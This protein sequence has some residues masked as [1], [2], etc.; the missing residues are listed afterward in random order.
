MSEIESTSAAAARS[1]SVG[2]SVRFVRRHLA[3]LEHVGDALPVLPVRADRDW[4]RI[5]DQ[6]L[7]AEVGFGLV[8]AVAL[9]AV[10]FE[11]FRRCGAAGDRARAGVAFAGMAAGAAGAALRSGAGD[12]ADVNDAS[13]STRRAQNSKRFIGF[14]GR[15]GAE[16]RS[17]ILP[18][19]CFS[20]PANVLRY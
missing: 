5:A 17:A 15:G 9:E 11:D 14:P 10:V 1:A 3:A 2:K 19:G 4:R 12:R 7:D 13:T 8:R 16:G 6:P 18:L 20:C